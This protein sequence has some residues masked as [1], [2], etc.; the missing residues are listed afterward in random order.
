M[1]NKCK[2]E[3]DNNMVRQFPEGLFWGGERADN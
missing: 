1:Y 3:E 2:E